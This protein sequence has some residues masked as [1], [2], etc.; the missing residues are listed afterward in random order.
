M[1]KGNYGAIKDWCKGAVQ[2]INNVDRAK[3]QQ[4]VSEVTLDG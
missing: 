4:I 2:D 1:G 3:K